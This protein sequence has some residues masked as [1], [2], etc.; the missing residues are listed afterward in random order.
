MTVAGRQYVLDVTEKP[1]LLNEYDAETALELRIDGS[2][3]LGISFEVKYGEYA[4]VYSQASVTAFVPGDWV[5][6][7]LRLRDETKALNERRARESEL[8]RAKRDA[9]RFGL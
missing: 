8:D 4:D 9:G 2:M 7:V 6:D 1:A 3:R 5:K